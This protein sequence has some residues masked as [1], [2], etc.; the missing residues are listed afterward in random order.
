LADAI[1]AAQ[2]GDGKTA[3]QP[4]RL[5]GGCHGVSD[6]RTASIDA[7]ELMLRATAALD[8]ARSEPNG[9]WLRDFEEQS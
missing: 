3:A 4:L 8:R 7:S 6:F 5:Y 1:L 9:S 2:S